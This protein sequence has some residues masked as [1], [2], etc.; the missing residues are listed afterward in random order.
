MS[1]IARR[2]VIIGSRLRLTLSGAAM[3]TAPQLVNPSVKNGSADGTRRIPDTRCS[4]HAGRV[5]EV[6]GGRIS[7][8]LDYYDAA[9]IMKQVWRPPPDLR[10][11]IIGN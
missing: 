10:V 2:T 4:L 6:R 7:R 1:I 8:N 5:I 9:T 11:S 3:R